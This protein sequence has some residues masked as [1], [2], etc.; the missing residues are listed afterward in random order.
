MVYLMESNPQFSVATT[1][2]LESRS[3][4]IRT[5]DDLQAVLDEEHWRKHIVRHHP[6]M[7]V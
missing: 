1:A 2:V 7:E 4:K 3:V 5:V 6:E